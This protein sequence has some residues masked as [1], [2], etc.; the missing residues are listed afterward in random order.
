MKLC[1]KSPYIQVQAE[2]M[3]VTIINFTV[4]Q[5]NMLANKL[6]HIWICVI[7]SLLDKS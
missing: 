1:S 3:T 5:V 7:L 2:K 6:I 4:G